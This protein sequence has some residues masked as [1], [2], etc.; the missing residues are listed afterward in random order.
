MKNKK[1]W[2]GKEQAKFFYRL[3]HLLKR[4]YTL[5]TALEFL[6]LY[7]DDEKKQDIQFILVNL[8]Q[9]APLF[10]SFH[11][12]QFS[13]EGLSYIYFAEKY[14]ELAKGFINAGKMLEMKETLRKNTEKVIRYPLFLLF[15]LLIVVA[16]MQKVLLPQFI[17]L[18]QSMNLPQSKIISLIIYIKSSMPII[19]LIVFIFAAAI[20]ALYFLHFRRKS[21][22]SQTIFLCKIPFLK[23]IVKKHHTYFFSFH[24]GNLLKNGLSIKEALTVFVQQSHMPFFQEEGIRISALLLEG[25]DLA[26]I[27]KNTIY[28]DKE[29]ATVI[30]HGQAN[31]ILSSE[32]LEY[33]GLLIEEFDETFTFWLRVLQP[34]IMAFL[35][36]FIVLLYVAVMYPIY[37]MMQSL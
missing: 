21:A 31:G 1:K 8:K 32:L 30:I 3:G 34:T 25:D 20:F 24:L 7:V 26:T 19:G 13:K 5:S 12:L 4:G 6:M 10:D 27:L 18:Y 29:L 33:S 22:I 16:T 17:Q 37:G 11:T 36:I 35:G 15:L 14:G 2:K 23:Y 9:G 28:Y